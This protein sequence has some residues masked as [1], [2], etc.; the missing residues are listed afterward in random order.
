M[1]A[2][3]N[4]DRAGLQPVQKWLEGGTISVG[5]HCWLGVITT[6]RFLEKNLSIC[7]FLAGRCC[8]GIFCAMDDPECLDWMKFPDEVF[9]NEIILTSAYCTDF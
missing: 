2:F 8:A 9:R 1:L 7:G 4:Q 3:S 5:L 6:G